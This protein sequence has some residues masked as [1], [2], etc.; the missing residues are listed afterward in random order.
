[1]TSPLTTTDYR[2][3][4]VDFL[5]YIERPRHS[6]YAEM[7]PFKD[8][9]TMQQW[10][11]VDAGGNNNFYIKNV[12]TNEYLSYSWSL[13]ISYVL[14]STTTT[15]WT[16]VL[17]GD[18]YLITLKTDPAYRVRSTGATTQVV[19]EKISTGYDNEKWNLIPVNPLPVE[20]NPLSTGY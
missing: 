18:S 5:T 1:M 4:S 17:D 20:N 9:I 10:R 12:K 13:N 2:I 3:Q 7:R 11:F 16:V 15:V 14:G 8:G 6:N 19:M